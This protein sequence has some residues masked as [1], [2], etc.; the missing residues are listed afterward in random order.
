M[1]GHPKAE[2]GQWASCLHIIDP[3]EVFPYHKYCLICMPPNTRYF[4]WK[5]LPPI[6]FDQNEAAFSIAIMPF[7][8]KDNELHLVVGTATDT[9]LAPRSCTSGFIR[10]YRFIDDGK[11]LELL[12]KVRCFSPKQTCTQHLHLVCKT[13]TDD[14]PLSLIGFQGRL[15]AGIGKALRIYEIGKKKLL[16]KCENKVR[17]SSMFVFAACDKHDIS[18]NSPLRS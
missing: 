17:V 4:Q 18:S 5:S 3:V 9:L 1:F 16:R 14:V 11:G 7:A 10:T 2:A 13:E 12:H 8:A 6:Q 15:L